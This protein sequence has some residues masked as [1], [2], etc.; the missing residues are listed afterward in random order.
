MP[1]ISSTPSTPSLTRLALP[2]PVRSGEAGAEV[3]AEVKTTLTGME[4]AKPSVPVPANR[5][6][7][8]KT[9]AKAP[10]NALSKEEVARQVHALQAKMDKLNPALAFVVDQES[11][12]AL[13]QLTDRATKEVILQFPSEAAL[14]ISKAL[15]QFQKGQL[16][17][18]T[19]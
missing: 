17:N 1:A 19:V 12:R 15:D 11:G 10:V 13:I 4:A 2:L 3:A 5:Q 9:V 7:A 8:S 16:L 18:R 14:Q 6:Q